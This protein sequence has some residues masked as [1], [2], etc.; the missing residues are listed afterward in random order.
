MNHLI[1]SF[2]RASAGFGISLARACAGF[3]RWLVGLALVSACGGSAPA[4]TYTPSST[5]VEETEVGDD[6]PAV[7]KR[8]AQKLIAA[9]GPKG[10]TLELDNGARLE[11][12]AGAL[13]E[14]VE[15]TFAEGGRTTA[16]SNR[17]Y[18]RP[19]GPTLE[20]A[21]AMAVQSPIRVSIPLTKMP[22]GFSPADVALGLEVPSSAHRAVQGQAVQTRWDYLSA[23]SQSGRAIA[24]LSEVPGYRVQ[25]VVS[26]NE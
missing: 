13:A 19:L 11:I 7:H 3:D 14:A 8:G 5:P 26:K 1:V 15:V 17:E 4:A 22:D 21:P 9:V 16:F 2:A 6:P 23:S 18:E 10:G 20:V 24:E 12:P 25:F